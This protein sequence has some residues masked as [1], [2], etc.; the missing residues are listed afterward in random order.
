[1]KV[2]D[3]MTKNVLIIPDGMSAEDAARMMRDQKI[4]LL[5]VGDKHKISPSPMVIAPSASSSPVCTRHIKRVPSI[6]AALSSTSHPG[7]M[8]TTELRRR[9]SRT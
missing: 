6:T 2:R 5:P 7:S 3:I 1:M 8:A 4:G 9:P